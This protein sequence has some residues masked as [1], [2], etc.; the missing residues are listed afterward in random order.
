MRDQSKTSPGLVEYFKVSESPLLTFN[1]IPG[2]GLMNITVLL[3]D[4][5]FKWIKQR[6]RLKQAISLWNAQRLMILF[7]L[8]LFQLQIS[9]RNEEDWWLWKLHN[10]IIYSKSLG[11][12][13]PYS[14]FESYNEALKLF[15]SHF[16]HTTQLLS[17]QT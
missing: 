14:L 1:Y 13:L 10:F 12:F 6:L 8:Q 16:L 4:S 3:R 11:L 15:S 7:F 17:L 5:S 2:T 9:A